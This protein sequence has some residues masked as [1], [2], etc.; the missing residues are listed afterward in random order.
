MADWLKFIV[1]TYA[2]RNNWWLF[3][4]SRKEVEKHC[5]V[6]TRAAGQEFWLFGIAITQRSHIL[7]IKIDSFVS[8]D[9]F[10]MYHCK[11]YSLNT[12]GGFLFE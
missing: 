12:F 1:N 8:W 6:I 10:Y 3:W 5:G 9:I 7:K 2:I 4:Y 11:Y